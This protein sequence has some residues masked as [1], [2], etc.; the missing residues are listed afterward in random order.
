MNNSPKNSSKQALLHSA[1]AVLAN[2]PGASL[3]DIASQA[4]V[5]RATLYRYFPSRDAL[6]RELALEAIEAIDQVTARV[7]R[8]NL[9]SEATLLAFLEGVVPLG[10]RFH[11]LVSESSAYTDLEVSA[12]Y[13][14]Q[15]G[16]LDEFVTRLKQDRVIALDI[17]N[18]WV[19]ATID[20][21]IWAAWLS[22]Q[23]GDI[24]RKDAAAFVYRTLMK[25]LVP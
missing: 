5:G 19:T 17:P 15:M 10:D 2:N 8:H 20:A 4:G 13:T 23:T 7:G 9:A 22:V 14:R 11:F 3:S 6:V 25:G 21:L 18:T 12:A 1:V 16:E 24:A